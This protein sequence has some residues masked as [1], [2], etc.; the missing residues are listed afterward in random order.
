MEWPHPSPPHLKT[1]IAS[2]VLDF[3][4]AGFSAPVFEGYGQTEC[5]AAATCGNYSDLSSG[6]VGG[7]IVC[8][9]IVTFDVPEMN[10]TASNDPP[11]GEVC[12]R[13]PNVFSGYFKEPEKTAEAL[14]GAGWLHSGDIGE[15]LPNGS[16]RIIDRKKNI[17]KL[18]QGE[19][20]AAEKIENV[21]TQSPLIAQCFVYGDSL[22]AFLVAVVVP[23]FEVV[24]SWATD[25]GIGTDGSWMREVV[26]NP[27]LNE[28]IMEQIKQASKKNGLRG[29]EIVRKIHLESELFSVA[30][31]LL[32]PTFKL[33]R[34]QAKIQYQT[35]I[36][37]MYAK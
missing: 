23:D 11:T 29:F 35:A 6:H 25:N 22:Q 4:R 31:D 10:Y 8:N 32:T 18:A 30:N 26:S 28:A 13:G 2:N 24:K 37:G 1:P 33:K 15:W 3:L 5:A 20:V 17:F 36:N 21:Y 7:P 14:D 34:P 16:I 9:E 19:Y 27:S 12:F